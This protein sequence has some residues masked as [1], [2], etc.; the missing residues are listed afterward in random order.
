MKYNPTFDRIRPSVAVTSSS[1]ANSENNNSNATTGSKV[2]ID[3]LNTSHS[4]NTT[5]GLD[6]SKMNQRLKEMFK[7][8]ITSFREAVYLLTGFRVSKIMFC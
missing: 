3:N 6:S 7:E 4:T 1:V 5:I 2:V 8:R